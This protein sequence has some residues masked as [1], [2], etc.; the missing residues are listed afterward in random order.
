MLISNRP[1]TLFAPIDAERV[2]A[3]MAADDSEWTFTVVH[4]PAGS[5]FSFINIHDEAGE[6][7]GRV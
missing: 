3:E 7:V 4:D 6:F 2:A 5:G 1:H